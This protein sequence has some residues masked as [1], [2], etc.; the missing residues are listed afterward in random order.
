MLF[1]SNIEA[2]F[3][4]MWILKLKYNINVHECITGMLHKIT[5]GK[6]LGFCSRKDQCIS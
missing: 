4:E 5:K 6:V 1:V 2:I 3:I